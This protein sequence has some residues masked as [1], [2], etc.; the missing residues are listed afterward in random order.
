MENGLHFFDRSQG[1]H[2]TRSTDG[3][4]TWSTPAQIDF[5]NSDASQDLRTQAGEDHFTIGTTVYVAMRETQTRQYYETG[6]TVW[7]PI[8]NTFLKTED[9]GVTWE[10]VSDITD[11][12]TYPTHETA[13]EYVG[14][15]TIVTLSR[16]KEFDKTILS[17]SDD[18]GATWS[19]SD[20]TDSDA[21]SGAIGRARIMTRSHAKLTNNWWQDPVLICVG[22]NHDEKTAQ[23]RHNCVWV[24]KDNG[25]NWY[26]PL[27]LDA[28]T[29]DSGY[30]H[31]FY[32][33]NT[34]EYVALLYY[35]SLT[36]S[37][38]RQ[39]NFKIIW[40]DVIVMKD[41]FAWD[42][43]DTYKWTVTDPADGVTITQND[44]SIFTIDKSQAVASSNTNYIESVDAITSGCI[45]LT[46]GGT[47]TSDWAAPAI[48][49]FG[50]G[51]LYIYA[52]SCQPQQ[53]RPYCGYILMAHWIMSLLPR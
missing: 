36:E 9:N 29:E 12:T 19:A 24:S 21:F 1:T 22:F 20:I 7:L 39:Y 47:Y 15:D 16:A 46:L 41:D 11:F 45:Q 32:N 31:W 52:K 25:D 28:Q 6:P 17:T 44:T 42:V 4:K 33:P 13:M 10:F 38:V 3:G 35:G 40:S 50:R 48:S 23:P 5:L 53:K 43:I 2:Q 49:F 8:K 30:G 14:N 27:W 51:R 34:D 37:T 26:G 18:L